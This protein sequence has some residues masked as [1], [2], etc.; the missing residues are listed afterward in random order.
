MTWVIENS[1]GWVAFGALILLIYLG[2]LV[3]D[4]R[5]K[6]QVRMEEWLERRRRWLEL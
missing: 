3:R 5:L 6:E 1:W 2:L 4:W